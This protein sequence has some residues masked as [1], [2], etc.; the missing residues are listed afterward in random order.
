MEFKL[1]NEEIIAIKYYRNEAFENINQ[2]LNTDSRV[3]IALFNDE[4]NEENII[5]YSKENVIY[6]I[7][8]IKNVY[9][10]ILKKYFSKGRNEDWVF[11]KKS[12]FLEIE[13]YRNEPFIDKFLIC[14]L[15]QNNNS[16][17]INQTIINI[18]GKKD[19]PYMMLKDDVLENSSE[20]LVAL[21]TKV[22]EI[23][24]NESLENNNKTYSMILECQDFQI[25]I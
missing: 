16:I 19:V 2:F 3:D 17:G 4:E 14:N 22:N 10:A 25:Y 20:I 23:I 11:S 6:Y 18:C 9:S 8:T 12:S 7:E 21:F 13:K 1:T 15:Q 5:N 24:E